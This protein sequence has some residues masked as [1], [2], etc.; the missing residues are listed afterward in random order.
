M[1]NVIYRRMVTIEFGPDQKWTKKTEVTVTEENNGWAVWQEFID[2]A[3][4]PE[5][6]D[7]VSMHR[8]S[9]EDAI[10]QAV[11]IIESSRALAAKQREVA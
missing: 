8:Y 2:A 6:P 1:N 4:E 7:L 10:E 9:R 3:L 11:E 5:G